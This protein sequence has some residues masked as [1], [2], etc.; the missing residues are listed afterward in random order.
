VT[1][2]PVGTIRLR[3]VSRRYKLLLERNDTLKETLLRR[4]RTRTRDVWALRDVD[5][6]VEPGTALGVVGANGAGK[7]TLLKILAGILPPDGGTVEVSGRVVSL[8]E[9]GA[10]F[11]PDFT[12][13]ENVIL[14]ASIHGMTRREVESRMDEIIAFSELDE[15]FIDAP[16]R[17]Y[18][19]GMFTRLGF[20]IAVALDPE[21]LLLDEIL[22]VGDEAFQQKCIA[23]IAR[24]M[25]AATTVVFVS[26]SAWAIETVCTRAI[27][28]AGGRL[29]ADGRPDEV[30][31]KYR[32]GLYPTEPHEPG[33]LVT[34]DADWRTARI[35]DVRCTNGSGTPVDRVTAGQPFAIEVDYDVIEAGTPV[36]T[37]QLTTPEGVVIAGTDNRVSL[38]RDATPGSRTARFALDALPLQEGR[39]YL[40]VG[41]EAQGQGW[42]LDRL[43]RCAEFT[44]FSTSRGYGPVALPG[45]WEVVRADPARR[46]ARRFVS[47]PP[48]GSSLPPNLGAGNIKDLQI[49]GLYELEQVG[50]R[51][52]RWTGL[53]A[54]ATAVL[55]SPTGAGRA[56]LRVEGFAPP[57][58]VGGALRLEV[59]MPLGHLA[60]WD[61]QCIDGMPFSVTA[62]VEVG[63]DALEVRLRT[64]RTWIPRDLGFPDDHRTLGVALT[65]L[66]LEAL[67]GGKG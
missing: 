55:P 51:V 5:L 60:W 54:E 23:R 44:V 28:L 45:A 19:S 65:R 29:R 64:D 58:G 2:L 39:F 61:I 7:S 37:L 10:G 24:F 16:V 1:G 6:D 40:N 49:S 30:I 66:E 27:W 56:L 59:Q 3:G 36:V 13:R 67:A 15:R 63:G 48:A 42:L 35:I 25:E 57:A 21:V 53:A 20:S 38:P 8:L 52:A 31:A 17:T 18:S 14:N 43:E 26:H 33:A 34:D 50:G 47:R 12:G 11:H 62:P 46:P 32:G 22:A 9:L 4:R 41:L